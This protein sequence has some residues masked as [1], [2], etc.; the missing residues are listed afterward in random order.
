MTLVTHFPSFLSASAAWRVAIVAKRRHF[1]SDRNIFCSIQ[2][3]FE[4][5]NVGYVVSKQVLFAFRYHL[6]TGEQL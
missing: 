3:I 2:N 1:Y 6:V 4:S 5:L